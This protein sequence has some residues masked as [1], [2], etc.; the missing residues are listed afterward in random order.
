ME[1]IE[2]L[3]VKTHKASASLRRTDDKQIIKT[4]EMLADAVEA[5]TVNILEANSL[6]VA[7]QDANDSRT[8]RLRL[9]EQRIKNI[10][11][12]IRQVSK[13]PNPTG[14]IIEKRTLYNGLLLEKVAVPLG[15]VGAIYESRPN[16][17]FDIAT[18]CLRSMNGCL[19]KGSS[20][21]EN[22]NKIAVQIIKS[23]LKENNIDEDCVT[24]LP[25]NRETVQQL[26]TATKYV[27]VLIPRGSDSLI[28][29]V[30][31]NSLVPVIETGAGRMSY[32]YRKR[33][34]NR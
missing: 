28:Q 17:T 11:N 20:E 25:S 27:D 16:V 6:D 13:L 9:N 8:D 29:S 26:Y 22:S 3:I 15:V 32:L 1:L 2:P 21:A 7:K 18:L 30:R 19:L 33:G 12:S 4:L 31:K 14:T 5:N 24:L 10:A 23:V 34:S